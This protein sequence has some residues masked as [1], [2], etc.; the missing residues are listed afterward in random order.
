MS[1][2]K[3]I[4]SL[5][6]ERLKT[7]CSFL[8]NEVPRFIHER[9]TALYYFLCIKIPSFVPERLK[10][11]YSFFNHDF[12]V[13]IPLLHAVAT[14]EPKENILEP[15]RILRLDKYGSDPVLKIYLQT[16]FL[17]FFHLL[18]VV[19]HA[20]LLV[21]LCL[22]PIYLSSLSF[23]L[24][25]ILALYANGMYFFLGYLFSLP[26]VT[27][28]HSRL[29]DFFSTTI[30]TVFFAYSFLTLI[31]HSLHFLESL[32]VHLDAAAA[33]SVQRSIDTLWVVYMPCVL[34]YVGLSDALTQPYQILDSIKQYSG[35]V[36]EQINQIRLRARTFLQTCVSLLKHCSPHRWQRSNSID[37][38]KIVCQALCILLPQILPLRF[39]ALC[40][41][42]DLERAIQ[43]T[44]VFWLSSWTSYYLLQQNNLLPDPNSL[45]EP[46]LL[47]KNMMKILV[48]FIM[49]PY[50]LIHAL[51][52][53][54]PIRAYRAFYSANE[55]HFAT[56]YTEFI[57]QYTFSDKWM[58]V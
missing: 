16:F 33:L 27:R 38:K 52:M 3:A 14:L 40:N 50:N 54:L 11:F 37:I 51:F 49:V 36:M 4:P 46:R 28:I 48:A 55:T 56:K 31:A 1:D 47:I 9:I 32:F 39:L 21:L 19:P 29:S 45:E 7:F 25:Y 35:T 13:H 15:S 17:I 57:T 42:L 53:Q 24:F 34:I 30:T 58:F 41:P 2:Q 6:L 12:L 44:T 18:L 10:T 26:L 5:F 20:R 22:F 23:M 43:I 8:Y